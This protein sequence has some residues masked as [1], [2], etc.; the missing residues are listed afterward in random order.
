MTDSK[1][2]AK[3]VAAEVA[4]AVERVV[5]VADGAV[6]VEALVLATSRVMPLRPPNPPSKSVVFLGCQWDGWL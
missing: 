6:G 2:P 4:P 5:A 3:V 1:D